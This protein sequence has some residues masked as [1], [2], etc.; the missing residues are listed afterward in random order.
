MARYVT[1]TLAPYILAVLIILSACAILISPAPTATNAAAA[2]TATPASVV[3]DGHCA[4]LEDGDTCYIVTLPGCNWTMT[5]FGEDSMG[6][7]LECD[8]VR[9]EGADVRLKDGE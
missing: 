6:V 9:G 1:E 8:P 2:P 5:K 3:T 4:L 7:E